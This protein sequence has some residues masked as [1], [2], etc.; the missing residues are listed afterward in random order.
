[1]GRYKKE[2]PI[3]LQNF[4]S[5][6]DIS[7]K[8]KNFSDKKSEVEVYTSILHPRRVDIKGTFDQVTGLIQTMQRCSVCITHPLNTL[9]MLMD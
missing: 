8:S 6:L 4:E 3:N 5:D 9:L 2:D 7:I 1:M